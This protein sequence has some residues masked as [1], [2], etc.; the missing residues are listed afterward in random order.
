MTTRS[1]ARP[2]LTSTDLRAKLMPGPHTTT[3]ASRRDRLP[4]GRCDSLEGWSYRARARVVG[5]RVLNGIH[6]LWMACRMLVQLGRARCR[7]RLGPPLSDSAQAAAVAEWEAHLVAERRLPKLKALL[8]ERDAPEERY[9]LAREEVDRQLSQA[10][11]KLREVATWQA[12]HDRLSRHVQ[13]S[14]K[15]T[16]R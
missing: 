6:D 14:T 5:H 3:R 16:V 10:L 7:G 15:P 1:P 9:R 2:A 8:P 4:S 13:R 11:Q 12:A